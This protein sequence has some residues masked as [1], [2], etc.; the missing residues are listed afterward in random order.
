MKVSTGPE[1]LE[2][3]A[4]HPRVLP[5]VS[6]EGTPVHF[7]D[8]W[9][10]CVGLEWPEGGFVFHRHDPVTFE[11]HTLFLPKSRDVDAKA[12]EALDFIFGVGAETILTQVAKD[13]PHVRRFA[14][15]HGFKPWGEGEGR[16]YFEL[17]RE[18]RECPQQ[19]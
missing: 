19:S 5:H 12:E 8:H 4:N 13:L 9:K 1:F 18:D 11:V 6:P 16:D 7:G 2:S 3:V 17:T 10:D 14:L 15:R